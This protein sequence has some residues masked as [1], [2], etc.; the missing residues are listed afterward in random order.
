MAKDFDSVAY[1][2]IVALE[3]KMIKVIDTILRNCKA[4]GRS[5]AY[6]LIEQLIENLNSADSK[7]VELAKLI[8]P[9]SNYL[10]SIIINL[11]L[12]RFDSAIN[13]L[14]DLKSIFIYNIAIR[15]SQ[16][17]DINKAFSEIRHLREFIIMQKDS[18]LHKMKYKSSDLCR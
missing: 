11:E 2:K 3:K 16:I 6:S 15:A 14:N 12:A 1:D 10:N 4:E 13:K 9:Y 18:I 8:E 7:Q 5:H 17:E